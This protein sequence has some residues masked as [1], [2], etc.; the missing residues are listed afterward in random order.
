MW[1]RASTSRVLAKARKCPLNSCRLAG[2]FPA[3]A[4]TK[5]SN[6]LIVVRRPASLEPDVTNS[7]RNLFPGWRP[8]GTCPHAGG[9]CSPTGW[10]SSKI[11]PSISS[12]APP[13]DGA[14]PIGLLSRNNTV[15]SG[16]S[17]LSPVTLTVM[18]LDLVPAGN[19]SVPAV[20]AS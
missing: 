5:L 3:A 7:N 12:V 6:S 10:S 11:V 2:P 8:A 1:S 14:A 9:T 16:S 13:L 17:T 18:V 19:V 20:T 15:S 4:W